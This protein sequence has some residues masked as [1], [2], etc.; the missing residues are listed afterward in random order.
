MSTTS[1]LPT[2]GYFLITISSVTEGR[3]IV[4][5][6]E[7]AFIISQLQDLLGV[8]SLLEDPYSNRRLSAHIDLLA[9]SISPNSIQLLLFAISRKSAKSLAS[10][11]GNRLKQYKSEYGPAR[12]IHEHACSIKRLIGSHQALGISIKLHC[13]HTDWEYDRYSS[14][15]FYLHDRRGDWMRTWRLSRLYENDAEI[16]RL[17]IESELQKQIITDSTKAQMIGS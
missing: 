9:Y 7:R 2:F 16:Y 8:R 10:L 12:Y 6:N 13:Q 11:I 1:L 14:I 15:G 17:L 5:N 4:S 3:Y